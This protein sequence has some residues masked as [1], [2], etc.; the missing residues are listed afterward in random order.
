MWIHMIYGLQYNPFL[1]K[2]QGDIGEQVPGKD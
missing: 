1:F 2:L